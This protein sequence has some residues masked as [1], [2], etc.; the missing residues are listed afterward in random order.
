MEI[1]E[2]KIQLDEA[3]PEEE[4][5]PINDDVI[6]YNQLPDS[7]GVQYE[8]EL[9]DGQ[10]VTVKLAQIRKPRDDQEWIKARKSDVYYK[11][12]RFVVYF[13]TPNNDREYYSGVYGFKNSD[14]SISLPTINVKKNKTQAAQ[15]FNVYKRY[16]MKTQKLTDEE[17]AQNYGLRQFMAFLNSKPKARIE[18]REIE[19]DDKIIKKNFI[20]EFV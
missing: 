20:V 11:P 13:D 3:V 17:F 6:D 7:L 9:L 8:R 12:Y 16:I 19:F 4:K 10:V 14:G 18:V 2:E 1:E 5:L 15:L